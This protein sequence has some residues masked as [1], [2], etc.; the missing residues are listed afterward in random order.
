MEIDDDDIINKSPS[1]FNISIMTQNAVK[2]LSVIIKNNYEE[3]K[4]NLQHFVRT[5]HKWW[6][7]LLPS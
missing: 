2:D 5:C 4:M 7:Q 3:Q 6:A 1:R